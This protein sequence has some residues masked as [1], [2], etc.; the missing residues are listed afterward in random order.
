LKNADGAKKDT[1][2]TCRNDLLAMHNRWLVQAGAKFNE[3]LLE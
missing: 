3:E 1:P 2:T